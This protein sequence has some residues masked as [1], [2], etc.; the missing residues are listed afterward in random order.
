[1]MKFLKWVVT[2]NGS[3]GCKLSFEKEALLLI[4][5]ALPDPISNIRFITRPVV[6][7]FDF[8]QSFL[9]SKMVTL[10]MQSLQHRM[11]QGA[12]GD[13]LGVSTI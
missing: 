5:P 8:S 10:V 1:M 13:N 3:Q 12:W 11:Y 4:V 6:S 9:D 2:N 7:F